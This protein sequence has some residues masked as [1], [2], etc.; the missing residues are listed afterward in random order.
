MEETPTTRSGSIAVLPPELANQIA[1]GEVVER[2]ASVVKELVENSVDAGAS[3]IQVI[4]EQA[5]RRLVSVR[6]NGIGMTQSEAR[7]SVER[8]ATSKLRTSEDLSAIATLGFR[9]EA[10]P[11]IA[12][13]SRM[14]LTTRKNDEVEGVELH[15][16][17]GSIERIRPTACPAGTEVSV[18][19]LF[20]N[21]PARLKFLKSENTEKRRIQ[22]SMVRLALA[23]PT[24]RIRLHVDGRRTMDAPAT[25]DMRERASMVLGKTI[26][27][28]LYPVEPIDYGQSVTL[29]GMFGNPNATRRSRET[30]YT[31]VNG[32]YVRDRRIQAAITT[33]YSGLVDKGRFPVVVLHLIVPLGAVDVNVH[34]T[35]TE[36]R[37][38]EPD[39]I[40]RCVRRGLMNGLASAPWVPQSG[41]GVRVYQLHK[42]TTDGDDQFPASPG[43]PGVPV[44]QT[45]TGTERMAAG[46]TESGGWWAS[47]D[48]YAPE[49]TAVLD[50][51]YF[52]SLRYIGQLGATYL[53]LQDEQGLV[54]LDQHAAHERITFER[55]KS[56]YA[57]H[58]RHIQNL[59]LPVELEL[60]HIQNALLEEHSEFFNKM[61]FEIDALGPDT[62]VL[63]SAP[64]VLVRA[65]YN[66][67]IRDTLDEL[68]QSG[69]SQRI[70]EAVDAVLSRM[71]CHGSVRAGDHME[72]AEVVA[73]LKQI[74]EID[75]RANCP[76]GR[77]VFFRMSYTEIEERFDRR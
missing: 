42:D 77:P 28:E 54:L 33:A 73:L 22:Q 51:S 16:V 25:T 10:L 12:S 71:A 18:R 32:R 11:S 58:H 29:T 56:I 31:F 70:D 76:H 15:I 72:S 65:P 75:F 35:K 66:R 57:G 49:T 36:V 38:K 23:R 2:P 21:T 69:Y 43:R 47:G 26:A 1:A 40:F 61:G 55:L 48:T 64:A 9:G 41:K 8:H 3:D 30:M 60:D 6:D 50:D 39:L 68:G 37:F 7:L 44:Q 62:F 74:D 24:I 19:D 5:G 52:S 20:F 45:F 14:V 53:L 59:L 4:V 34:P 63:R 17:G 67:L 13:V 27:Q 46:P